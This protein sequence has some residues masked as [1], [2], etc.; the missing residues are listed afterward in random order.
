MRSAAAFTPQIETCTT[1]MPPRDTENKT[2]VKRKKEE[3]EEDKEKAREDK[4][5]EGEKSRLG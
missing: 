5:E 2:T 4:N 1:K 3:V